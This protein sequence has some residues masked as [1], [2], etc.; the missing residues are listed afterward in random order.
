MF[1]QGPTFSKH[2]EFPGLDKTYYTMGLNR[3]SRAR[4]IF[5]THAIDLHV[6][7]DVPD[8]PDRS[9]YLVMPWAPHVNWRPSRV[10]LEEL[11]TQHPVLVEMEKRGRL[12]WYNLVTAQVKPKEGSP[13]VAV[14]WFSSEAALRL[15]GMAGV[16]EVRML[17]IDGGKE[18]A[19]EFS[20]MKPLKAGHSTYSLQD[21]E[22]KKI[23]A[24]YE[25]DF[26]PLG[27]E[28]S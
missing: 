26:R 4:K 21:P 18:L 3:V 7:N 15:L 24:Y 20:F 14:T 9:E 10:T 28:G 19:K 8:L 17:G 12:L 22:L 25:I 27:E 11:A 1:G 23:A 5:M 16:K 6:L 13:V 2:S